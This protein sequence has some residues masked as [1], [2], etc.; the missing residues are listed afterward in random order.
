MARDRNT[1]AKRQRETDQKRK[2]AEKKLR[3]Q[4]R[5]EPGYVAESSDSDTPD[6]DTPD[7][8][9]PDSDNRPANGQ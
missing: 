4:K 6:S 7:S 8:D 1:F 9:T 3:R 5:K 2:A